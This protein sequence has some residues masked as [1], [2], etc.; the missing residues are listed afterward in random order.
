MLASRAAH[1]NARTRFLSLPPHLRLLSHQQSSRSFSA[2][3]S[4]KI[5]LVDVFTFP[6]LTVLKGL[7]AVGIPWYAAIPTTAILIRGVF[8][9]YFSAVPAR[10]RAQIRSNLNPLIAARVGHE[11][12]TNPTGAGTRLAKLMPFSPLVRARLY[13]R[14]AIIKYSHQLGSK[15]RAGVIAWTSPLQFISLIA[16]T[17]AVRM[18]CGSREGLLSTILTPFT[19]L[20]RF[21]APEYFPAGVNPVDAI[22]D[23]YVNKVEQVRQA[24]LQSLQENGASNGIDL[25]A[26]SGN[27]LSAPHPLPSQLVNTDAPHFD[28]SLQ[29]EGLSWCTDLT[30][31]DPM[32]VLPS[33]AA[34]AMAGNILA[35]PHPISG[36]LSLKNVLR[37]YSSMQYVGMGIACAFGYAFQSAPAAVI[38]YFFSSIVTGIVQRKLLDFTMPLRSPIMPCKRRTRVRN[39]KQFNVRP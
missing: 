1:P 32:M 12:Q 26:V 15:F 9:Y 13:P 8:G 11:M 37:R 5:D 35:N 2:S 16:S 17:E 36:P 24:R 10:R 20:G 18:L 14:W 3:P 33:L 34:V 25:D 38:L 19:I 6:P 21:I 31:V 39:K 4:S 7:H 29:T 23:A 27:V 30:A 28:P 22:A